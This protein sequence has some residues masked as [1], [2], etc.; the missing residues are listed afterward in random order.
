MGRNFK[1]ESN[2]RKKKYKRLVVDVDFDY[3]TKFLE[4]LQSNEIGF[5]EWVKNKI[6]EYMS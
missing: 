1:K 5:S 2:W 6:D 3:A 4:K